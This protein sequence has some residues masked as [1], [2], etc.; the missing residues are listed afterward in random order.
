MKFNVKSSDLL[1]EMQLLQGIVER[2]TTIPILSNILMKVSGKELT[3]EATDLEVSLTCSIE[4][5]VIDDGDAT[6][7]ARKIY[8]LIRSLADLELDIQ[9]IEDKD[10]HISGE[11]VDYKIP[12][13]P[14]EE[15]PTVQHV[16]MSE[17]IELDIDLIRNGITKTIIAS[18]IDDTRYTLNGVLMRLSSDDIKF[19]A[20]DAHRLAV[21]NISQKTKYSGEQKDFIVPRKAAQE[22]SNLIR[23]QKE[24]SKILFK[25]EENNLYFKLHDRLLMTRIIEG[26]YPQYEKVI[27]VEN[28]IE[29]EVDRDIF[30]KVV[31]RIDLVASEKSHAVILSFEDSRA[32]LSTSSPEFGEGEEIIDISYSGE[33]IKIA[34]NA[35][36]LIDFLNTATTEKVIFKF[37]DS[38]TAG[39]FKEHENDE[40]MYIVSP[41]KL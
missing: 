18:A 20:T 26:N 13:L 17:A 11:N 8:D 15:Y 1:S 34:F 10:L 9:T 39:M 7:N 25:F 35:R 23:D 19:V 27:P 14:A 37:K 38:K 40:Y 5:D 28:D 22:L 6:V 4:V 31:N 41:I 12:I 16:E 21:Y 33:G 30:S 2:K 3:L 24:D 36:Y 32:K 29:I